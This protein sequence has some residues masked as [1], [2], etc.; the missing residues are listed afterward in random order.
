MIFTLRTASLDDLDIIHAIRRD[1]ILGISSEIDIK[2]LQMWADKRSPAFFAD[3]LAAGHVVIANSEG[4]D[5]GWGSSAE[6]WITGLYVRTSWSGQGVGRRL[7]AKLEQEIVKRGHVC[8]R[9]D[10]S[11][12]A[13]GFYA[14]LGYILGEFL[15]GDGGVPMEKRFSV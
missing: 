4:D 8:A 14:S 12:N 11:T 15:D 5:I 7:I 3:R 9:L 6:D 2:E 10:A 13:V 1:A